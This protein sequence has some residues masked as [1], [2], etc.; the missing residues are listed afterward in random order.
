METQPIDL[1]KM[2]EVELWKFIAEQQEQ[3][4]QIISMA[5]QIQQNIANAK[6]QVAK[7]EVKAD[8]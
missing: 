3:L 1:T 4:T 6:V 2:S 7:F 5:N 8:S